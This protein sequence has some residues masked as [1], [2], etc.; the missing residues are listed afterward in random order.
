[1]GDGEYNRFRRGRGS[2]RG[3]GGGKV[4]AGGGDGGRRAECCCVVAVVWRGTACA[5]GETNIPLK[6]P[7]SSPNITSPA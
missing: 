1:M 4:L 5:H 2:E 7:R 3:G 6:R